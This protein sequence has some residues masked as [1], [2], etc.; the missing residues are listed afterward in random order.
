VV[1][2]SRVRLRLTLL[3]AVPARPAR[4]AAA[5]LSA[6]VIATMAAVSTPMNENSATP[7]AIPIAEYRLP[8]EA[9]NAAEQDSE[10]HRAHG[11]YREHG[12]RDGAGRRQHSRH[13]EHPGPDDGADDQAGRRR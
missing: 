5:S 11:D 13:R 9:L 7:A 12:E 3:M 2:I 10:H 4:M 1:A 8:P 6:Q